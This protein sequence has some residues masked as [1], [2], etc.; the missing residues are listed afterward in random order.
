ME[1]CGGACPFSPRLNIVLVDI[2]SHHTKYASTTLSTHISGA[3]CGIEGEARPFSSRYSTCSLKPKFPYN[4]VGRFELD[5]IL[6]AL[7]FKL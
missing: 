6:K 4:L 3:Y 5:P 2:E 1:P 7:G